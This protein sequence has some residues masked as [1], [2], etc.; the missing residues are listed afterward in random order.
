LFPQHF[1]APADTNAH[2][3]CPLAAIAVAPLTD[4]TVT[5]VE[6]DVVVPSPSWPLVLAP[7]QRTDP[8]DDNSAHVWLS[9]AVMADTLL[10]D[11]TDTAVDR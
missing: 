7:Q 6:L 9:P 2:V 5:A 3:K 11:V 4:D 8:S 1:T 10:T